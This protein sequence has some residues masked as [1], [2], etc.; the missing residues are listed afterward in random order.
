MRKLRILIL[1]LLILW[2]IDRSGPFLIVDDPQKSDVIVVLA[3]ETDQ[4]PARA[5][6]LLRQGYAG[7]V[8]FDVPGNAKVYGSTYVE[9]AQ[10]WAASLPEASA[11]TV[12]PIRGLSTKSEVAE[13]TECAK[14][15]GAGSILLVS[16]DFHT[17]RALSVFKHHLPHTSIHVAAAYDAAQF[18]Q[19][20]WRQRQ[21]AKTNV[22]EWLRLLWWECVDRWLP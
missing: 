9:I 18:G 1:V 13:S 19:P 17:R 21:W 14:N 12:C 3:G 20:W 22:D 4:R 7:K 6:E 10:R 11:L 16:S 8:V 5:L 15:A 2:L